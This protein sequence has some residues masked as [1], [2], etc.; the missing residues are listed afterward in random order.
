MNSY[1]IN[2][3]KISERKTALFF[4]FLVVTFYCLYIAGFRFILTDSEPVGLYHI[5]NADRI[6]RG[7]LVAACPPAGVTKPAKTRGYVFVAGKCPGRGV[8]FLKPVVAVPGD[9]V[10]VDSKGVHVNFNLVPNSSPKPTDT[11][12]APVPGMI[13]FPGISDGYWLVSSFSSISY[14][15]RDWDPV[16]RKD[17]L[18]V[19]DPGL[20]RISK[21]QR[22]YVWK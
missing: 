19:S 21:N 15:S 2:F 9:F 18:Y 13:G 8:P 4:V 10:Q 16:K 14:D 20:V 1:K 22:R 17:I 3:P 7:D 6:E 5:E 12:G 11:K